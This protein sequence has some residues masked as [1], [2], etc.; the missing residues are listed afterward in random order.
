MGRGNQI[1]LTASGSTANLEQFL[2][3][4]GRNDEIRRRITPIVEA[5]LQRLKAATPRDSG[6]T[7]E[8]WSYEIV[9]DGDGIAIYWKNSNTNQGRHIAI[10]IRYGHGTRNGGYVPANDFITPVMQPIFEQ[11]KN[12]VWKAVTSSG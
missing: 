2:K 12:E 6:L 3:M 4:A 8:S 10:L 7:A 11:I 1:Q 5:G 9:I